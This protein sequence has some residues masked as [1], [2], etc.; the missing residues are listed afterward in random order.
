MPQLGAEVVAG[1]RASA[2]LGVRRAPAFPGGHP[3]RR[4]QRLRVGF[5]AG[6]LR[7]VAFCASVFLAVPFRAPAFFVALLRAPVFLAV[8]LRALFFATDLR[9]L[10]FALDLRAVFFAADLRA[11][12]FAAD[13]RA[14]F[15]AA[16]LRTAFFAVDLRAG[17]FFAALL[18][19]PVFLVALFFTFNNSGVRFTYLG[20][21]EVRAQRSDAKQWRVTSSRHLRAYRR[22][23]RAGADSARTVGEGTWPSRTT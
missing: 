23:A 21:T 22:V 3:L 16:P 10:F 18:R 11:V 7:A 6:D 4:H 19:A 9:A 5:R 12:F 15:F 17:A 2:E 1:L 14:V 20:G 13:F 8:D